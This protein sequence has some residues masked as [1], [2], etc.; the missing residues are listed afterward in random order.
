[1]PKTERM[2]LVIT[3]EGQHHE[4]PQVQECSR[5]VMEMAPRLDALVAAMITEHDASKVACN[6][7]IGALSGVLGRQCAQ[8]ATAA[9]LGGEETDEFLETTARA[10]VENANVRLPGIRES[11]KDFLREKGETV[12]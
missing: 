10:V 3:G 6:A 4:D 7:V 12:Q 11:L 8:F 2:K 1:M 9:C 5:L